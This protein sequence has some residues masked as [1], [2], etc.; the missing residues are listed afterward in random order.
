MKTATTLRHLMLATASVV[1]AAVLGAAENPRSGET[2]TAALN[3]AHALVANR[4]DFKVVRVSGTSMLPFFGNGSVLVVKKMSAEKLRAGMVVVYAN[5]FNETVAHRL[6]AFGAAGWEAK[7]YNNVTADSTPVSDAN[8]I[9]VVYATFHSDDRA[10]APMLA[11]VSTGTLLALAA[12][13]R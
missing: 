11:S 13:A 4:A 7:G 8:L 2:L 1:F 9:G 10:E 5:R 12:P 6:V 3:D